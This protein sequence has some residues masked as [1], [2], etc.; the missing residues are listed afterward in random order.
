M[1][2]FWKAA[3]GGMPP[4][5]DEDEDEY[6][7]TDPNKTGISIEEWTKENM[8]GGTS[9]PRDLGFIPRSDSFKPTKRDGQ[10]DPTK[11]TRI[12]LPKKEKPAFVDYSMRDWSDTDKGP[13]YFAASSDEAFTYAWSII[14]QIS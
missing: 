11:K 10:F 9:P 13:D 7:D 12:I 5:K 1:K 6:D 14:K 3:M 4:S 2:P 8:K